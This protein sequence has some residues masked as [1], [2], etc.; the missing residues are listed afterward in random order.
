MKLTLLHLLLL[1]S[2]L[3]SCTTTRK[4]ETAKTLDIYGPG[5]I[6]NPV[7][8]DLDVKET[9]VTGSAV[10]RS[11]ETEAVKNMA[12]A[13]A[14]KKANVDVLVEPSFVIENVGSKSTVTVTGFPATYSNFRKATPADSLMVEASYMHRANVAEVKDVTIKKKG[15]GGIIAAAVLVA[16]LIVFFAIG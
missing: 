9:K 13:D 1:G 6:Q 11:K 7:I 14:I 2:L 4:V 15:K 3:A 5:V 12:L 10:G 16:G 8:A